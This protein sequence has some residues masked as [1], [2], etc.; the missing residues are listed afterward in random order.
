MTAFRTFLLA[1]A[2]LSLAGPIFAQG[3]T[4][5]GTNKVPNDARL[6]M[7]RNQRTFLMNCIKAS[8]ERF[9]DRISPANVVAD[10]VAWHCEAEGD[11][12]NLWVVLSSRRSTPDTVDVFYRDLALPFVLQSRAQRLLKQP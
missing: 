3:P 6:Q 11:P 4:A 1:V 5:D 8:I 2:A 10:A 9:D 12:E 7:Q